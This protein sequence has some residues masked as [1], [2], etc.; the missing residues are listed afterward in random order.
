MYT[1]EILPPRAS[2]IQ[3]GSPVIGTWNR[4]FEKVD[5]L[6]IHKPFNYPLPRWA[7]DYRIKERQCFY[8][9]NDSIILEAVFLNLKLYR[10][11]Q[12]LV[13]EKESGEKFVFKKIF[14]GTSWHLPHSLGNSSVNSN[15]D[16][17]YFRIHNWLDTDTIKL[18][19]NID[20]AR[21]R[22]ALE[23]HLTYN[24]S[25][26]QVTP[27]AV[28]VG[29]TA[30]RNIYAYK[31]LA[32][33]NGNIVFDG[34]NTSLNYENCSGFFCDYKGFYPYYTQTAI[35]STMGFQEKN[36]RFGFQ[37]AENQIKDSNRNNENALWIDGLLTPLPP[38]LVTMPDGLDGSWVIQDTEGMVDLTFTPKEL[39]KSGIKLFFTKAEFMA[40]VG[41][42]NGV[43]VDSEGKKI[44][45]KNQFG[46]GEKIYLRV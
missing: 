28:S 1:R 16:G 41:H 7:K 18:D 31:T 12:V 46:I 35:C 10:M 45:I 8:A 30:R 11:A 21:K 37:I 20:A 17:F 33:V 15:S 32:P 26:Q 39:N 6:D 40:H 3:D 29:V 14:P 27:M 24:V 34:R 38:V 44:I 25:K 22:P 13:Y 5:L 19:I 2:P 42:Y 9:Q 36:R 43:L 4:A 23:I